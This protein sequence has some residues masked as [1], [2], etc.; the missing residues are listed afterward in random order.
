M[1]ILKWVDYTVSD[2]SFFKLMTDSTPVH[3]SLLD[4]VSGCSFC[5]QLKKNLALCL[6]NDAYNDKVNNIVIINIF[7]FIFCLII[8]MGN[9]GLWL[10]K[11][12]N[13]KTEGEAQ[14][15]KREHGVQ[16]AKRGY[17]KVCVYTKS[18]FQRIM[19]LF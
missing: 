8:M 19:N 3:L 13:T 7:G 18:I 11:K 14:G 9:V 5:I 10:V 1:G 16:G 4:E 12:K 2:P 15:K 6:V 17:V